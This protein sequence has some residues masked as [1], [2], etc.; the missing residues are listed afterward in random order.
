[1]GDTIALKNFD[2][3]ITPLSGYKDVKPMV[4]AGIFCKEGNEYEELREAIGKLKL[5]DASLQYEPEHPQALGFGFRCGFLGLLHLEIIKERL[6]REYNLDLVITSPSVSY[7]I[8]LKNNQEKFIHSPQ[9]F[10]EISEIKEIQ[11]PWV[12]LEIFSPAQYLSPIIDLV[13]KFRGFY[14]NNIYEM[15]LAA[16]LENFYDAL[17]NISAGYA[18]LSYQFL[19]YRPAD[20]VKMDILVA[21]KKV[22]A[23]AAIVLRK[24]IFITGKRLTEQLK[25][26]IPRQ[27]FEISLQAAVGSKIISRENIP[28]L[29]KNVTAK[30]Y[31]GD[32]S[33]KVKLW[34]KQQAGKKKLK[35]IGSVAIPQEAFFAVLKNR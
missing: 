33:R 8:I 26:I 23:L 15:P 4:F 27:L 13:K 35:Q 14:K 19:D 16:F 31:G 29:K 2:G 12:R 22:E 3:H 6:T 28:A 34:K 10:P 25:K 18:S 5:T 20:L 9:E 7:K 1:M 21:G 11:E 17:K 24:E 32:R 30:L